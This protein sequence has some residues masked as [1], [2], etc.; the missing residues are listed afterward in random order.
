[1]GECENPSAGAAAWM[2]DGK[3]TDYGKGGET[4]GIFTKGTVPTVPASW[5]DLQES[6]Y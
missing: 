4:V 1:M 5:V 2:H 6:G 3:V